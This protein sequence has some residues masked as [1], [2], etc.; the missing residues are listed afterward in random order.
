MASITVNQLHKRFD[1]FVAVRNSSFSIEDGE[2][3]VILGPSGCGKTTSLRMIAGLE[4]PTSG[5]IKL[6]EDEVTYQRACHRDIAFMFQMFALYPHMNVR[7]NI[8]FPLKCQGYKRRVVQEKVQEVARILRIEH[9]LDS[10]VSG[11]SSGDRQRVALGRA[12]I[13][14]PKAFLMDE[15]L[16]ALDT[17]F[18]HLMTVELRELHN[19]MG[20]TTVYVTHDQLEAMSMADRI[21]VM[22][23]GVIEQVDSPQEIYNR[24]QT[25]FVAEFIGEPSMNFIRFKAPLAK[26]DSQIKLGSAEIAIPTLHES[27]GETEYALGARPDQIRLSDSSPLRGKVLSA[28]Y[29]GSTQVVTLETLYGKL[30][31]RT[32]SR[33]PA[34][35]GSQVGI[36]FNPEKLIIFNTESGNALKS[37]YMS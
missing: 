10:K 30:K 25:M 35:Y 26:G 19:R 24:P 34:T 6:G 7:G 1:D 28:E 21:M 17:E 37:D 29:F 3:F 16:G 2:F 11:L 36:E 8:S 14:E 32:E 9:L 5:E 22:N 20:A 27:Q 13:R 4:L 15:P 18:R 23:H 12:I 31:A 33:I